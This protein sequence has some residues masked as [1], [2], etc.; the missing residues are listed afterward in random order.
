MKKDLNN[1]NIDNF[2]R[3]LRGQRN[4]RLAS[5]LNSPLSQKN[6]SSIKLDSYESDDDSAYN[7]Y[8]K[9]YKPKDTIKDNEFEK[10]EGGKIRSP[11]T[12][13]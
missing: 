7:L 10:V 1:Q 4:S 11:I 8:W 3:H 9:D 2:E 12:M 5:I 6:E 13:L